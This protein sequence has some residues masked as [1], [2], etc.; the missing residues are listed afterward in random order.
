MSRGRGRGARGVRWL[1]G[2]PGSGGEKA[3]EILNGAQE[4]LGKL[5]GEK[6]R[7]EEQVKQLARRGPPDP[8]N[9]TGVFP[10]ECWSCLVAL[11]VLPSGSTL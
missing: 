1:G 2:Q 11:P 4:L 9:Q 5:K 8:Q 7:W 10:S 6:D 3:E